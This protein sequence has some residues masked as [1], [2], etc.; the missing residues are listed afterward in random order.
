[1]PTRP[2]DQPET[3]ARGC[4][5]ADAPARCRRARFQRRCRTQQQERPPGIRR[6][7]LQPL[8]QFQIELVDH[9]G[10]GLRDARTQRF[11]HGPQG[12]F[13]VRRLDKDHARRIEAEGAEA[14][15]MQPAGAEPVSRH[16]E[17]EFPFFPSPLWGREGR[18][19]VM[20]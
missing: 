16:D 20:L 2:R 6:G 17:E 10:D 11:F 18:G 9:P 5:R 12:V 19:V 8:A 1:M 14:M 4:G 13:A 7:E 15:A 3:I